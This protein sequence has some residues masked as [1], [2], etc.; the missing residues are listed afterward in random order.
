MLQLLI[1]LLKTFIALEAEVDKLDI[2]KLVNVPTSLNHLKTKVDG[3]DVGK[4]KTVPILG[5][6]VNEEVVK[7]K[8]FDSLN[9]K[10]PKATNLIHINQYRTNK[11]FW[12][13]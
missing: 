12:R 9:K 3:L 11:K 8:E 1:Q 4:L 10:I 13:K 5:V 6:L 7:N 2:N